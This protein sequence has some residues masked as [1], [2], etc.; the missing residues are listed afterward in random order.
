MNGRLPVTRLLS[1]GLALGLFLVP[2]AWSAPEDE[3][4]LAGTMPMPGK[5]GKTLETPDCVA[6]TSPNPAAVMRG[7]RL[8]ELR[9][10]GSSLADAE[11][12]ASRT[13]QDQ[14]WNAYVA[15]A[16]QCEAAQDQAA[17]GYQEATCR[18][19]GGGWR[20]QSLRVK[21]GDSIYYVLVVPAAR[22][23]ALDTVDILAGKKERR[24]APASALADLYDETRLLNGDPQTAYYEASRAAENYMAREDYEKAERALR[25]ALDA[26]DRMPVDPGRKKGPPPATL[27]LMYALSLSNQGRFPEADAQFRKV[28]EGLPNIEPPPNHK[29]FR[30]MHAVNQHQLNT[31]SQLLDQAAA[32]YEGL[33]SPEGEARRRR[34]QSEVQTQRLGLARDTLDMEADIAPTLRERTKPEL[35]DN[36]RA[37]LYL[38]AEIAVRRGDA[39]LAI[40]LLTDG[41]DR[42]ERDLPTASSAFASRTWSAALHEAAGADGAALAKAVG[43]L[44]AASDTLA[45]IGLGGRP[46]AVTWM[47]LDT[48]YRAAGMARRNDAPLF[49]NARKTL[50][51][52]GQFVSPAELEAHMLTQFAQARQAEDA[53]DRAKADIIQRQMLDDLQLIR[54]P[55][56]TQ[57]MVDNALSADSN[58]DEVKRL[59]QRIRVLEREIR[60]VNDEVGQVLATP[61]T[62]GRAQQLDALKKKV[63]ESQDALLAEQLVLQDKAPTFS[64]LAQAPVKIEDVQARLAGGAAPEALVTFMMGP[65]HTFGFRLDRTGVKVWMTPLKSREGEALI[66]TVRASASL[67]EVPEDENGRAYKA[68]DFNKQAARDLYKGLFIDRSWLT[69]AAGVPYREVKVISSG[70]LAT[71]PLAIL[72]TKDLPD[73]TSDW[74]QINPWDIDWLIKDVA[75]AYLPSLRAVAPQSDNAHRTFALDYLG[76]GVDKG[77]HL[78]DAQLAPLRAECGDGVDELRKMADL[79]AEAE[80]RAVAGTFNTRDGVRR[81]DHVLG[82]QFTSASLNVN[83]ERLRQARVV[84]FASHAFQA[85]VLK[86]LKEPGIQVAPPAEVTKLG[87]LFLTATAVSQLKLDADLV[88]LSAC[89][90]AAAGGGPDREPLSG[91]VNGFLVAGARSVMTTFWNAPNTSASMTTNDL[92]ARLRDNPDLSTPEALRQAQLAVLRAPTTRTPEGRRFSRKFSHP[93][94]WAVFGLVGDGGGAPGDGT[95]NPPS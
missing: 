50:R 89:S 74:N 30:A 95:S 77:S 29:I 53:G 31:A 22:Q 41:A 66:K 83:A 35:L 57:A 9:C 52:F 63:T 49:D 33:M 24:P 20:R 62:P 79:T 14:A 11:I 51:A 23:A 55:R 67:E 34:I 91:L 87:D 81:A 86:C 75:I 21:Q 65:N 46:Q 12:I 32:E 93:Y 7:A 78:T 4:F 69:N 85:G 94:A 39:A 72:I 1:A 8:T 73:G 90:T 48:L 10:T 18:A 82:D 38:Q 28:A 61:D 6:I 26:W 25:G 27:L 88:V 17:D 44:E 15:R 45:R 71:L 19:T 13:P 5:D 58:N 43:R 92:F 37:L 2:P 42:I 16:F 76:F 59:V 68:E 54:G 64:K 3:A 70:S 40:R 56:I 84:H 80:V 60:Q 36:Y 47:R